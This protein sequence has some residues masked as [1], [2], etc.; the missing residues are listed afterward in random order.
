MKKIVSV[1]LVICLF[2]VP[3][4]AVT[5]APNVEAGAAVLMEQETG[6]I[7]YEKNAHEA[8]QA[9][10]ITKIMTL[11]L[12]MEAIDEGRLTMD[13]MVTISSHAAGMGGLQVYLKEGEQMSVHDLLK[14]VAITS[15]NDA[16]VALGE[17]VSGS[18]SAFTAR[19]NER[20][21]ELGLED[22]T[23]QNCTGLSTDGNV[24]SAY[25]VALMSRELLAHETIREYTAT[26]I[27]SLRNG[28]FQLANTNKLIRFYEGATGLHTGYVD[29]EGYCISASAE[30]DGMELVAVVF[31]APNAT[32]RYET[33]KSLL[34]FGFAN[35]II[36]DVKPDQALAPIDV[37]LGEQ[38]ELQPDFAE[39]ARILIEK[40]QKEGLTQTWEIQGK[41]EAPVQKGQVL[42]KWSIFS[43]DGTLIKEIAIIAP[44][45]VPRLTIAGLFDR[46]L[47]ILLMKEQ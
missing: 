30:R 12:V 36:V 28:E 31:G 9:D 1:C 5:G 40:K 42:G 3:A 46:L 13:T 23:F 38:E 44:E 20:A 47:Q 18:E 32:A 15:G 6:V 14:A 43:S 4:T 22:T 2:A 16:A 35:Y 29:T 21:F 45:E 25:D 10:G 37:V 8:Q 34:N 39:S 7:L 27:D 33:A 17:A 41:V 24:T 26:W 19:M 11:L